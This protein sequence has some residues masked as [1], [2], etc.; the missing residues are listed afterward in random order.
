MEEEHVM[1]LRRRVAA[2]WSAVI[3]QV[4]RRLAAVHASKNY[5]RAKRM[6]WD[7]LVAMVAA[8]TTAH[9]TGL[10]HGR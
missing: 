3:D 1:N 9:L 2:L 6:A 4:R 5:G 10:L 8:I 7:V